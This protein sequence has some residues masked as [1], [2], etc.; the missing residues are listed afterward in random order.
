MDSELRQLGIE[1]AADLRRQ[2][3]EELVHRFGE[4]TGVFLYL[5]ARG[6][7][8]LAHTVAADIANRSCA[9]QEDMHASSL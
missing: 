7:V 9:R 3:K 2:P 4:R 8:G 1:T 5:A 6:R